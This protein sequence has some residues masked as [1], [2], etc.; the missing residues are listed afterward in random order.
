M[1]VPV[2]HVTA[3]TR[4][5]FENFLL[6]KIDRERLNQVRENTITFLSYV[7]HPNHT[8]PSAFNNRSMYNAEVRPPVLYP[9]DSQVTDTVVEWPTTSWATMM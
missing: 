5:Q 9:G 6:G 1:D 8:M 4:E 2:G 3:E 7:L